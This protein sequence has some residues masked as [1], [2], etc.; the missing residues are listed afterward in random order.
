VPFP[1]RDHQFRPGG[2]GGPG[3][4]RGPSITARLNRLLRRRELAGQPMPD[5]LTIADVAA[6]VIA[7]EALKGSVPFMAML[8]ERTDGKAVD[9]VEHD[10][11]MTIRVE[12]AELVPDPHDHP[13][14]APPEAG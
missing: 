8:L 5:G 9:R 7:R 12:Y 1:S 6:E 14:E 4:P 10:G 13:A 11:G 2:P 3:R